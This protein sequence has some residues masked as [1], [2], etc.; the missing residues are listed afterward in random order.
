MEV[1]VSPLTGLRLA[2]YDADGVAIKDPSGTPFFRGYLPRAGDYTLVVDA[3]A[4]SV[5][6]TMSVVL[7]QRISFV[8][9]TTS[10]RVTLYV[11]HR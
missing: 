2:I 7:A 6:Y 11:L 10:G 1:D 8:P 3:G 4:Q 5:S 9:G